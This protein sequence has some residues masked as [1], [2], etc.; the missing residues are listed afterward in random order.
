MLRNFVIVIA[1]TLAVLPVAK[2]DESHFQQ[3]GKQI[4]VDVVNIIL[5]C[6][7]DFRNNDELFKKCFVV[8]FLDARKSLR[9]AKI[10]A[11]NDCEGVIDEPLCR[12]EKIQTSIFKKDNSNDEEKIGTNDFVETKCPMATYRYAK[13][14]CGTVTV[15]ENRD[16]ASS[17]NIELM[18]MVMEPHHKKEKEIIKTPLLYLHGGPGAGVLGDN[19]YFTIQDW[20][21]ENRTMIFFDQRGTGYSTPN[22]NCF[23]EGLSNN[24]INSDEQY[25]QRIKQ[26]YNRLS[27]NHDLNSYNTYENA[28]D[29]DAIRKALNYAELDILG[30]SYGT[31][32]ATT[33][34]K[35]HPE[36]V[37]S[38]ILD[39]YARFYETPDYTAFQTAVDDYFTKCEEYHTCNKEFPKF[40]DRVYEQMQRYRDN[41]ISATAENPYTHQ[42]NTVTFDDGFVYGY[43]NYELSYPNYNWFG[44]LLPLIENQKGGTGS[45]IEELAA[46][47]ASSKTTEIQ[48]IAHYATRCNEEVQFWDFEKIEKQMQSELDPIFQPNELSLLKNYQD[49]CLHWQ[50]DSNPELD[51]EEDIEA[52]T[53]LLSGGLDSITPMKNAEAAM[54][55]FINGTHIVHPHAGHGTAFQEFC[56]E[57]IIEDFL[58]DP[59]VKPT[60]DCILDQLDRKKNMLPNFDA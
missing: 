52:P 16:D 55:I 14:R 59:E 3:K 40:R 57:E 21:L 11:R 27:K 23:A 25:R 17:P 13:I 10:A 51:E 37:R 8:K 45:W 38:L 50:A 31:K 39:G 48:G 9:K 34:A 2:A 28:R 32:L 4:K 43:L 58:K 22:L 56:N 46:K 26:C 7:S 15:P 33:Y 6:K 20:L 18:V 36:N 5:E 60:N 53:L 47:G 29:I 30:Q 35:L 12:F 44:S 19:L 24:L 42:V 54:N 49:I 41:P 1:F